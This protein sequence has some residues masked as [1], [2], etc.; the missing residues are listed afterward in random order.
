MVTRIV[1]E[2]RPQAALQ[3]LTLQVVLPDQVPR[4]HADAGKIRQVFLNLIENAIKYTPEGTVTVSLSQT[5]DTL[6]FA[7]QDTGIGMTPAMQQ[8]LFQ[9]F[10]RG[11]ETEKLPIQGTGLGLYVAKNVVDAHHGRI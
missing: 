6:R 10:T 4:V 3:H 8:Q 9:E 1:E 11:H 2:L 5:E 7:V